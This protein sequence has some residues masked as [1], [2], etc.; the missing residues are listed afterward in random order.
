MKFKQLIFVLAIIAPTVSIAQS[1]LS[2]PA[3]QSKSYM[4]AGLR[5]GTTSGITFKG[6]IGSGQALEGILGMWHH[7]ITTTLLYEKYLP[8]VEVPGVHWYYGGGG[9]FNFQTRNGF[10]ERDKN[11]WNRPYNG[12]GFGLGID[13]VIGVEYKP[14]RTPFAFSFDLKPLIEVNTSGGF[15]GSLDPGLGVKV[16]F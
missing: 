3:A 16:V 11:I 14:Q 5:L 13:G 4:A 1:T 9:H 6:F 8:I 10:Y 2:G 15:W 7:G 12:S